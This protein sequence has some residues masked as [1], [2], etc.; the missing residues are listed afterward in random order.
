MD[1]FENDDEFGLRDAY[2]DAKMVQEFKKCEQQILN[3][4]YKTNLILRDFRNMNLW[5]RLLRDENIDKDMEEMNKE[6]SEFLCEEAEKE[7]E[8]HILLNKWEEKFNQRNILSFELDLRFECSRIQRQ[9]QNKLATLNDF[10]SDFRHGYA[11][12]Y[13][14]LMDAIAS[15]PYKELVAHELNTYSVKYEDNET[16]D[17]IEID[18][19]DDD[20]CIFLGYPDFPKRQRK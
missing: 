12:H 15:S 14:I 20:D 7:N 4:D 1:N 5:C 8:I 18:D 16:G 10:I 13:K 3:A 6:K 19:E 17:I 2:E 11:N 9:I